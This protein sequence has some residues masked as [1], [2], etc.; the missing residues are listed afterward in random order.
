MARKE[1]SNQELQDIVD[2]YKKGGD[3]LITWKEYTIML[4]A[5]IDYFERKIK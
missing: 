2:R 4:W 1:I 5:L 3:K